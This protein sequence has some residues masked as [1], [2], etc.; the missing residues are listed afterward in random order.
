ME[1]KYE[2]TDDVIITPR[3]KRELHRI[4]A[5]RDFGNVKA[6]DLGGFIEVEANL[7][8]YG[9]CWVGEDAKVFRCARVQNNAIISGYACA[10]GHVIIKKDAHVYGSASIL[11]EAIISDNARVHG[12]AC[13][14]GNAFVGGYADIRMHAHIGKSGFIRESYDYFITR[15]L[16]HPDET[17]TMYRLASGDV[18]VKSKYHRCTLR[19]LEENL[20]GGRLYSEDSL[21]AREYKELIKIAKMHFHLE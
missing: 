12:N 4:R 17:I 19:E 10:C 18:F 6:G 21:Y 3:G 8:H 5:L 2:L 11:K 7:S 13:V 9:N 16:G 1:K 15:G 14:S 20:D